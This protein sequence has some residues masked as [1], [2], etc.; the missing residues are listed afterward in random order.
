M[1]KVLRIIIGSLG[2]YA[3]LVLW[4][5]FTMWSRHPDHSYWHWVIEGSY[6]VP[7]VLGTI[8]IPVGLIVYIL[9]WIIDV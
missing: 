8:L 3:M 2:I 5:S 6:M 7:I 4:C 9:L 1:N